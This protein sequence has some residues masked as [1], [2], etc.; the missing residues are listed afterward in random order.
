MHNTNFDDTETHHW[1]CP[2]NIYIVGENTRKAFEQEKK[3]IKIMSVCQL[4]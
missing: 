4:Q 3:Y 1:H 2:K